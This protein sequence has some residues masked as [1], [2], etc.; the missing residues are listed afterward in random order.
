M[1]KYGRA[2]R[3]TDGIILRRKNEIF[4]PDNEGKR[5]TRS[6]YVILVVV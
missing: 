6:Y 1:E 4:M 5:Q 2:R 3:A